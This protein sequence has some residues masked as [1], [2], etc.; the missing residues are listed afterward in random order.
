MMF[1]LF[2]FFSKTARKKAFIYVYSFMSLFISIAYQ[3]NAE[4]ITVQSGRGLVGVANN[5]VSTSMSGRTSNAINFLPFSY[6]YLSYYSDYTRC[7]VATTPEYGVMQIDG[8][9][10]IKLNTE[11][12]LMLVPEITYTDNRSWKIGNTNYVDTVTAIFNGYGSNTNQN[13]GS[14]TGCVW[15]PKQST[16]NNGYD[17][18]IYVTHQVSATGRVL[19]YGTGAQ[20][21]GYTSNL[22]YPFKIILR[23]P[24]GAGPYPYGILFP[25]NTYYPINVSTLGCTLTTPTVIDFGPQSANATNGQLLTTKSDGNLTVNCQQNTNP[26]TATLSLSAGINPIYFSGNEYEINLINNQNKAGAYVTM[27]LNI[28]GIPTNIPFNRTPVDIGTIS[29]SNS[30]ASF[31]YPITYSLYSRGTGITGKVKGSAEL[32]IVLR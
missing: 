22:N 14:E 11:G 24:R 32:S 15:S 9:T 19:I 27:S 12:T 8:V 5:I 28:N 30:S 20:K 21:S 2:G 1:N 25:A 31:S 6:V 10:G 7:E 17:N 18:D 26:M 16:P 13:L 29:A 4:S 3:A 23:D